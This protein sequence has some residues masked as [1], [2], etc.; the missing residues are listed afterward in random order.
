MTA[1]TG[2]DAFGNATNAAFPTRYQF[3]GR[4]FDS[5][6]GLQFSRA[7]FYDP[8]LGRFISEDPIGFAGGDV[9]LY[10]YVWNDP[11]HFVDPDGL[12][13]R[14]DRDHRSYYK[15]Q[16]PTDGLKDLQQLACSI[17][18]YNP[19]F[20]LEFGGALQLGP[21]G[22]SDGVVLAFNPLTGEFAGQTKLMSGMGGSTGILATAGLQV[23]LSLGPSEAKRAGGRNLELFGDA[24][25]FGGGSGSITYEGGYGTGLGLGPV[26]GGGAGGGLRI[27]EATPL[28]SLN[29]PPACGCRR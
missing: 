21:V 20:T 18:G 23:G 25:A 12:Q 2:Y 14:S 26:I 9:N 1:Q 10:G 11:L 17:D 19:W 4:E 3:T 8:K 15:R 24:A 5:F 16:L 6:T 22:A 28:F 29:P 7:R 13:A 27:G